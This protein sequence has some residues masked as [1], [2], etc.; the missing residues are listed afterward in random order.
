[1]VAATTHAAAAVPAAHAART[2]VVVPAYQPDA[3]LVAL[4]DALRAAVPG[5][6]VVVV[7]D[8]SDRRCG[9]VFR[10]VRALGGVVLAVPVNRGKGHALRT[11]VRWVR[12]RLPGHGVVCA[13][14]DGQHTVLDVLRVAARSQSEPDAVVLGAR[15]FAG[16]VPLR[17]RV[18]NTATRWA[19]TAATGTRVRDTQTGLRAY[20]PGLLDDLL[21]VRGDRYEYEL[22]ALLDATRAGRRIVEVDVAT[23]YLDDNASSHFR[24]VAD[25]LRVWAPLLRFAASSLGSAAVDVVALLVLHALTGSLLAAV[26]GARLLSAGV[27]FAV[28]RRLVFA[29]GRDVP[30]RAAVVRYAAL[31][32]VLLA[33]SYGLLALLTGLGVPLLP[34]KVGTDAA[35]FATSYEVQRRVVFARVTPGRRADRRRGARRER[36]RGRARSSAGRPT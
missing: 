8:G 4:V 20:G 16:D 7:D 12:D 13:D 18:G 32:V 10:A 35:L 19:F 22:R 1:M 3:R 6:P 11:G 9:G 23:V 2:A 30:L 29:G 34:A 21:A 5:L 25:S 24:P 15:R 14:A 33:A 28:N 31:A 27:N 26:V 17:S 36:A